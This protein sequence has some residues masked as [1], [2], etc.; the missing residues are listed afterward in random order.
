MGRRPGGSKLVEGVEGSEAA[1]ARLGAILDCLSG[2]KK[3]EE[4]A[5]ELGIQQSMFFRMRQEALA[6]AVSALE[7]KPMGRPRKDRS[8]EEEEI[9]ALKFEL[10]RMELELQAARIREEI[11]LAMPYLR[12]TKKELGR[13]GR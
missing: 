11:A 9:E 7:P 10:K 13:E 1:K 5:Q 8:P 12:K 4:A 2:R 3:V 6:G